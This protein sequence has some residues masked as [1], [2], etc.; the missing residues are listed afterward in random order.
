M[1]RTQ[2]FVVWILF[3]TLFLLWNFWFFPGEGI[4]EITWRGDAMQIAAHPL[5]LSNLILPVVLG[6]WYLLCWINVINEWERRPVLLF[7]RYVDT[8]GP[9]LRF[10]E[11]L[12]YTTLP[13]VPVQD[14]VREVAA[15]SVQTSENVSVNLTGLLTY[16]IDAANVKNAVVQVEDVDDAVHERALSTLVDAA[17]EVDLTHLLMERDAFC[18]SIATKLT[19]RVKDWGVTVKAFEL[20][21]FK[22]N[23]PE[24][25]QAIAMKARAQKEGEA[26][27]TRAGYQKRVAEALNE[28]AGTFDEKGRWLKGM[29]VLIELTRSAENNTVLIPTDLVGALAQS[30]L[31]KK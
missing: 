27:L 16:R 24:V 31:L 23:D 15:E 9:G 6:I 21:G 8:A 3:T 11:P 4:E 22:I 18:K 14:V 17:S 10:I 29:E 7:G 13:D 28:A 5:H 19:E 12:F 1:R 25:E 20:K 30:G 2:L 26:E